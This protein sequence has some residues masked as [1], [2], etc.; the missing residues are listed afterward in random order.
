MISSDFF[1]MFYRKE[2]IEV[3]TG[4]SCHFISVFSSQKYKYFRSKKKKKFSEVTG[5]LTLSA[6]KTGSRIKFCSENNFVVDVQCYE[7]YN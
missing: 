1:K 3:W 6:E 4:S 2:S 5:R 7:E